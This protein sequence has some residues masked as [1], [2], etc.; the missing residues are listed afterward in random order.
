MELQIY[1]TTTGPVPS[2]CEP[3]YWTIEVS[4]T[5]SGPLSLPDIVSAAYIQLFG[6]HPIIGPSPYNTTP[7]APAVPLNLT[8]VEF[9]DLVNVSGAFAIQYADKIESLSIPKLR[10]IWTGLRLDLSGSEP[11]AINLSFPSLYDVEF[12]IELTG[13][14]DAIDMPVLNTTWY[15]NVTSTGN[16]DCNAFVKSVLN[17]TNYLNSNDSASLADAGVICNSKRGSVT[18]YKTHPT[19]KS[20]G[21]RLKPRVDL[22]PLLGLALAIWL[23]S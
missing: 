16:L 4:K 7:I 1:N 20:G 6:Q 21:R 11:P 23:S 8:S 19:Q 15:I 3:F 17:A 13:N 22:V 10:K 18:T 9:P 5:I 12:G 2:N 14:I